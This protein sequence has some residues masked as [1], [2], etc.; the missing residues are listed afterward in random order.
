MKVN[1]KQI[2]ELT[3]VSTAT[4]SNAL[5]FKR[6]VNAD[7]AARIL[8]VAKELRIRELE[9]STGNER[10]LELKVRLQQVLDQCS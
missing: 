5:N 7:T 4:V 1:M 2:S 10:L 8:R 9:R 3:G 6:G